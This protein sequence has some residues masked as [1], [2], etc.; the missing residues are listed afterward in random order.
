MQF[1]KLY[2]DLPLSETVILEKLIVVKKQPLLNLF[3][4]HIKIK[5]IYRGKI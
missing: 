5:I 3:Y 2:Q 4:T 1:S